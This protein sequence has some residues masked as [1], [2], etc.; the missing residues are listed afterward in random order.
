MLRPVILLGCGGSGQK[1]V[2]Y[3]RD[4]VRR[5]LEHAGWNEGIPKS[6]QFLAF[7]TV[8]TQE[9]PGE[10]P[11]IPAKDYTSIALA[12]KDY[13]ALEGALLAN[14]PVGSKGYPELIGWRPKAS[15]VSVPLRM[16]AGAI[17]AVGRAAGVLSL[18]TVVRPKILNAFTE[19]TT[20]MPELERLCQHL[21]IDVP[22]GTNN[23]DPVV[24]VL[25]SMAGGTG[26]GIMLDMIDLVRR[27]SSGGQFPVA[28]V[29]SSDIFGPQ[30][31]SAKAAN[32]LAF[33]SELMSAYWDNEVSGKE[34]IPTSGPVTTRGP[35][36]VYL[37]GRKN[38]DG[39]DLNNSIN[40]YRA[41]GEA[42]CGWVTSTQ[43]QDE[44]YTFAITNWTRTASENMGGYPFGQ[45]SQPGVVSSFGSST[46]SIGRDRFREYTEKL[47]MRE[48]LDFLDHGH[49]SRKVDLFGNAADGM[50]PEAV[51]T[52]L[53]K[54]EKENFFRDCRIS[55]RGT[56]ENQITDFFK[57][58]E[59]IKEEGRRI[60]E[61]ILRQ[62]PDNLPAVKWK[63]LLHAQ[64]ELSRRSSAERA[65]REFQVRI[66]DWGDLTFERIL[67]TSS[68]Y[69]AKYGFAVTAD[70]LRSAQ[71][72]LHE[73]A[74]EV[75]Q[76]GKN[77]QE[78]ARGRQDEFGRAIPDV[79]GAL[80]MVSEY[81]QNAAKFLTSSVTN[82]WINETSQL[83]AKAMTDLAEQVISP[84]AS[85]LMQA[86]QKVGYM[87]TEH[88]GEPA[89]TSSWPTE[90]NGVPNNFTPSPVEFFLEEHTTWPNRLK[91][92]I[93]RSLP[94]NDPS[95]GLPSSPIQKARYCLIADEFAGEELRSVFRP[96]IW[97]ENEYG[98][99]PQWS[100]GNTVQIKILIDED[101]LQAR[102]R[103]WMRRSNTALQT[104]MKEGLLDYLNDKDSIGQPVVEHYERLAKFKQKLN[105]ALN[106]SKPLIELD[107]PLIA[108][109]HPLA[110][111]TKPIMQG[112][113]FTTGHPA[114]QIVEEILTSQL[115]V[116]A[117]LN[118]YFSS[119]DTESVLISSILTHPVHPMTVQSFVQPVNTALSTIK[120]KEGLLRGSFWQ[121]TRTKVLEDSIPL[122]DDIRRAMIRGFVVGRLLGYVTADPA[123]PIII[124]GED[125][126]RHTFPEI[127]LTKTSDENL[128]P[129][130]MESFVLCFG[131]VS[132]YGERA[133]DAY[134]QLFKLGESTG[135][136][137]SVRADL[138]NF[139]T[140]G[141]ERQD[142]IVDQ[143]R[144]HSMKADSIEGR[145]A[146][147]L[148]NLQSN[149]NR[150]TNLKNYTF[151]GLEHRTSE[152]SVV[153]EVTMTIELLNDLLLG[154]ENV[155]SA[156]TLIA[157][158]GGTG[159]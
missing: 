81:V 74:A 89:L 68:E 139:L 9:S 22:T 49:L 100:S 23:L 29:F 5:H 14:F 128:L 90:Q 93:N 33:M 18:Q 133:F 7:D 78:K 132:S 147:L 99:K 159:V 47:L 38:M 154:Y 131:Q 101:N 80:Q 115:P 15:E 119:R 152:G 4:S 96:I 108:R 13:P 91:D 37:I 144:A 17:R 151:T 60:R 123:E 69:S 30:T 153:P 21:G 157:S 41:V 36:A 117:P 107:Y 57:S 112:F 145:T 137:F 10:I 135:D 120:S 61:D 70:L 95:R 66:S 148:A 3:V 124:S 79:K 76:D 19:C 105:E 52:Q 11:T 43:V 143:L 45:S 35:H 125:G 130:L 127:L 136:R 129:A 39:I 50:T 102:V 118:G 155:K 140:I 75:R 31:N 156:I 94:E 8:E 16:G 88:D 25:G 62:I 116:G 104:F 122:P 44:I 63:G 59:I 84:I 114:R 51:R 126:S 82:D 32:G 92:L 134:Q 46:I 20:G 27:T 1:A 77:A 121:W 56:S 73:V 150:Y 141:E 67:R 103:A 85:A 26:A 109:V 24:I 87:V 111:Q 12:F 106:Q 86:S 146:K 97:T 65:K 6:W 34:L 149:I 110:P 2:R 158:G 28:L 71:A 55:E 98:G 54:R 48:T 58:T 40:V 113:P 83:V 138:L 64:F 142:R 72:E 53:V 42:L